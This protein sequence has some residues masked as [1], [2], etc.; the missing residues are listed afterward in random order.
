M[1]S[2]MLVIMLRA[3]AGSAYRRP[4]C[5]WSGCIY[6]SQCSSGRVGALQASV[7]TE[8]SQWITHAW[9]MV[10]ESSVNSARAPTRMPIKLPALVGSMPGEMSGSGG[11]KMG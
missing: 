2:L 11:T 6:N 1:A 5:P 9:L 7:A 8:G 10:L 3:T 4:V